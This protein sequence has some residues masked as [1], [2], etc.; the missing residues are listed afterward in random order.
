MS[1]TDQTNQHYARSIQIRNRLLGFVQ[2]AACAAILGAYEWVRFRKTSNV[3][4]ERAKGQ[5]APGEPLEQFGFT[6]IVGQIGRDAQ[7]GH[8]ANHNPKY[9][10]PWSEA[11]YKIEVTC[12]DDPVFAQDWAG[13]VTNIIKMLDSKTPEN[14]NLVRKD[15][16]GS[17]TLLYS[18]RLFEKKA[19]E[20]PE[21]NFETWPVPDHSREAFN[22]TARE[23]NLRTLRVFDRDGRR[24]GPGELEALLPGCMA[25]IT[26]RTIH[27]PIK[28]RNG[29]PTVHSMS[30]DI[31]EITI[32]EYA[33]P[34]APNPF[35][36][37][38]PFEPQA[39]I[40]PSAAPQ[41][42]GSTQHPG[43]NFTFGAGP[44]QPGA[45]H[46][47]NETQQPPATNNVYNSPAQTDYSHRTSG[48][49]AGSAP[50]TPSPAPQ[51]WQ[52]PRSNIPA[53]SHSYQQR[54]NSAQQHGI[55]S[56][57]STPSQTP[58]QWQSAGFNIP[59]DFNSSQPP[60]SVA[61]HDG[62]SAP[63]K[64]PAR[65]ARQWQSPGSDGTLHHETFSGPATPSRAPQQW[66]SPGSNVP[67]RFDSSQPSSNVAQQRAPPPGPGTPPHGSLQWQSPA[68]SGLAGFNHSPRTPPN[69]G[70]RGGASG[71]STPVRPL[72][73]WQSLESN[74]ADEFNA[75]PPS[76]NMSHR[77]RPGTN[78]RYNSEP[79]PHHPAPHPDVGRATA[80][81]TPSG[82][83]Q[84]PGRPD[85]RQTSYKN[86][87]IRASHTYSAA[88]HAPQQ[89]W[90]SH[91]SNGGQPHQSDHDHADVNHPVHSG[92]TG[93]RWQP[94]AANGYPF[95][96][97]GEGFGPPSYALG[98]PPITQQEWQTLTPPHVSADPQN[99]TQ[100]PRQPKHD[101]SRGVHL[102]DG[103][104]PSPSSIRRPTSTSGGN[105]PHAAPLTPQP[106]PASWQA[107]A[108]MALERHAAAADPAI[109]GVH[110]PITFAEEQRQGSNASRASNGPRD[111]S[112]NTNT[113]WSG[114]EGEPLSRPADRVYSRDDEPHNT[115]QMPPPHYIPP[116]NYTPPHAVR[117]PY[118]APVRCATSHS[119]RA[120]FSPAYGAPSDADIA[121]LRRPSSAV[122]GPTAHSLFR[123]ASAALDCEPSPFC[124]PE[125]RDPSPFAP[126]AAPRTPSPSVRAV[127][128]GTPTREPYAPAHLHSVLHLA[129]SPSAG[130]SSSRAADRAPL[131]PPTPA[132][133]RA[134]NPSME[135]APPPSSARA[136]AS[137]ATG[138]PLFFTSD[139]PPET[140]HNQLGD[141]T[142]EYALEGRAEP[143]TLLPAFPMD[144]V[145]EDAHWPPPHI[146]L[147]D[148]RSSTPLDGCVA[149]SLLGDARSDSPFWG[150]AYGAVNEAFLGPRRFGS[151]EGEGDSTS[152]PTHGS[153]DSA[154]GHSNSSS[155]TSEDSGSWERI[156]RSD[157]SSFDSIPTTEDEQ[158]EVRDLE[159]YKR[160]QEE[161]R[162][163]KR[164]ADE[165]HNERRSAK[166]LRYDAGGEDEDEGGE[167]AL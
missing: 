90:P 74:A 24:L 26:T 19:Y 35:A 123:G 133:D 77:Q 6:I 33:R 30:G 61:P 55:S 76:A 111:P 95:A 151:D 141:P 155:I 16:D 85:S 167:K 101:A 12:P 81:S 113:R 136:F 86:Q 62:T 58:P 1:S 117:Y 150:G 42:G 79:Q 112:V 78:Q 10:N 140:L 65:A 127:V 96:Y 52:S 100:I 163:K 126:P 31:V 47:E 46:N 106:M 23:H 59:M 50:A 51:Q 25:Q 67:M 7:V 92:P 64:T 69:A 57:P 45:W 139:S 137:N 15:S 34:E 142:S 98:P 36:G 102:L 97:K 116:P 84:Q 73:Q 107:T 9:D 131:A 118:V 94:P 105:P 32:L 162:G 44:G 157:G 160:M 115:R 41:V 104:Q 14:V 109:M 18:K 120:T 145:N 60:S 130:R 40:L 4:R 91:A 124:E 143:D 87:Q 159:H 158:D 71:P 144:D 161:R 164:A 63:P 125:H 48:S 39:H 154:S 56:H 70:H 108:T 11:R 28:G 166:R 54:S 37:G 27:W 134:S 129:R 75:N 3:L 119:T 103:A 165:D 2:Y 138:D 20:P 152:P 135:R 49:G 128:P 38:G 83:S 80:P 122:T 68:S 153:G 43:S 8:M 88:P 114:T 89:H 99:D 21:A 22:Q 17:Y 53:D 156:T 148:T 82:G 72:R 121:S 149:P 13:G 29:A 132:A 5:K 110:P 66:Q 146:N 147:N 93:H